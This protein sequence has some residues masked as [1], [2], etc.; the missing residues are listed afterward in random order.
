MR[1]NP[2]RLKGPSIAVRGRV[3]E[4]EETLQPPTATA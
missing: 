4:D 3:D 2:G 1:R